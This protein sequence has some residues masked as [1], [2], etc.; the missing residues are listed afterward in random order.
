[1]HVCISIWQVKHLPLRQVSVFSPSIHV[2][3]VIYLYIFK[4]FK[5]LSGINTEY[6]LVSLPLY[7]LPVFFQ[8][9]AD[10]SRLPWSC[11]NKSHFSPGFFHPLIWWIIIKHMSG[12]RYMLGAWRYCQSLLLFVY[13]RVPTSLITPVI[14]Y[15]NL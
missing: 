13:H 14:F 5:S 3:R 1:M 6:L 7:L 15:C 2:A 4:G 10:G 8:D 9:K 11:Y 12:I